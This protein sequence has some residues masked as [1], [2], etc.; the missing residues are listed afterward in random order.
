MLF[1]VKSGFL[2]FQIFPCPSKRAMRSHGS[3]S[4]LKD[5]DGAPPLCAFALSTLP[6]SDLTDIVS[7]KAGP[8][9]LSARYYLTLEDIG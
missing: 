3:T 8:V 5:L 4:D 2:P 7:L 9:H 1:T 6:P